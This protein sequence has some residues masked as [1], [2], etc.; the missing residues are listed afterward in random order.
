MKHKHWLPGMGNNAKCIH[1]ADKSRITV[2]INPHSSVS[3]HYGYTLND[4]AR[5]AKQ[6]KPN[7]LLLMPLSSK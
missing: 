5:E 6:C 2:P 1:T 3:D 4:F 7:S